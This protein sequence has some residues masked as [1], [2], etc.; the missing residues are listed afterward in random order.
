MAKQT[1][2]LPVRTD[3]ASVH[4]C[5]WRLVTAGTGT[6]RCFTAWFARSDMH[7]GTFHNKNCRHRFS[8]NSTTL[9]S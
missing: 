6:A 8:N 7:N 9:I 2:N 4:R 3:I 5:V 1:W